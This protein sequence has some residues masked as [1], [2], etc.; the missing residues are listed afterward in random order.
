M[1]IHCVRSHSHRENDSL[2]S[3]IKSSL[4]LSELEQVSGKL[5]ISED[6]RRNSRRPEMS[7]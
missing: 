4:V 2:L 6:K 7:T 3:C 1:N 5:S